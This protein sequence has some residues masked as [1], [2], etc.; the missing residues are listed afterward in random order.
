MIKKILLM[1]LFS[2]FLT[3]G[4]AQQGRVIVN[5]KVTDSLSTV[6]NTNIIN[7]KTKQGTFSSDNGDFRI[8]VRDGDSLRISSIQHIT[9][10]VVINKNNINTRYLNV[11]LIYNTVVLDTFELKRHNLSGSLGIDSKSVPN[12]KKDSLLRNLMDFSEIEFGKLRFPIDE[13]DRSKPPVVNTVPN[14]LAGA[15]GSATIPF[16][17]SERLWALR[18]ELARKKAF[19]YKIMSELGEKFF[20]DNLKIPVENYFHF[21]EYCN[22]LGIEKLHKDKK[23]L[24]II[25]ILQ[26]ESKTYLEIIKNE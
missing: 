13:I 16:K 1:L 11:K 12:S 25:K 10:F 3:S 20:F 15:G 6:K 2:F 24:D 18:K 9:K 4:Y 19:P 17:D 5:G 7:I 23:M 14:S 26:S 22:P 21:L 8:F